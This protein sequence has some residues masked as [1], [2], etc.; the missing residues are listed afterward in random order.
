MQKIEIN[1]SNPEVKLCVYG[2]LREGHGNWRHLLENRSE[3][4]G[5]IKTEPK[6]TMWGALSGF[7]IVT[8]NGETSIECDIIKIKVDGVLQ[9]VFD[10]EGFSGIIGHPSNWYD[11]EELDLP[12]YGKCYMFVQKGEFPNLGII[13][14]GNWKTKNIK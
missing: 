2:T 4:L 5:T 8:I 10:L 9:R 11:V 1:A 3:Y 14:S 12:N 7:P 13:K 6:Y